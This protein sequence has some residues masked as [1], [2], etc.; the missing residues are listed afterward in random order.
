MKLNRRRLLTTNADFGRFWWGQALSALGTSLSGMALPL[1][2][3]HLTGSAVSAGGVLTVRLLALNLARLPGGVLA[4]RWSRRRVMVCTDLIKTVLWAMPL[5]MLARHT[6]VLWPLLA[7]ALADGLVSSV[8]NPSLGA[9]LR[10]LVQP[11]E[12]LPAVSLYEARSYAAGLIGPAAGGVLFT[13]APWLPFAADSATYAACALLAL[14]IRTD[15]GGGSAARHGL[16]AELSGGVRFVLSQPFLRLQTVWSAVLNFATSAA[17]FGFIPLLRADGVSAS[18]IGAIS[19]VIALGAVA[20][21]ML[22]PRLAESHPYRALIWCS[23]WAVACCLAVTVSARPVVLT[24]ALVLLSAT[25]PI[26]IVLLS[27]QVYQVIPDEL[28]ARAQSAMTLL[29]SAIYPFSAVFMG[30]LLERWGA[31]TGYAIVSAGLLCCL[32]LC[33]PTTVRNQLASEPQQPE[34][35]AV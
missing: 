10:R 22:A 31:R 20:G 16:L 8:Y 9:A 5:L 19:A 28:M 2:V 30:F 25:G 23:G 6:T 32:I 12:L 21:A 35:V 17:F 11:H 27:A 26:L 1:L 3:L 18:G 33:L 4:D 7:V 14:R 34:P 24:A 15:L 29:G 13:L